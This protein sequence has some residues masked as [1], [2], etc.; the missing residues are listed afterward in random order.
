MG[1]VRSRER[2]AIDRGR[3]VDDRAAG[4]ASTVGKLLGLVERFSA[5]FVTPLLGFLSLAAY[6]IAGPTT[7]RV[8]T[9][10]R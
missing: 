8:P 3:F 9:V 2:D 10:S 4:L 7:S 5:G 1:I 6:P